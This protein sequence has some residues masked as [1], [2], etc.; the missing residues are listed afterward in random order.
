MLR[1]VVSSLRRRAAVDFDLDESTAARLA[2]GLGDGEMPALSVFGP[3]AVDF[4]APPPV[5][6]G[7]MHRRL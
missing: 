2:L 4:G 6:E 3:P 1:R 5:R 7:A